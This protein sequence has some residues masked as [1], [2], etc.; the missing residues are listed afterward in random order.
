[1]CCSI[2]GLELGCKSHIDEHTSSM[3]LFIP[4]QKI[5]PCASNWALVIP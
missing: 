5:H 3:A 2:L 4:G 1:M